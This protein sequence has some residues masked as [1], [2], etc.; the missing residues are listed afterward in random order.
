MDGTLASAGGTSQLSLH[1]T[2]VCNSKCGFCVVG[3]PLVRKDSVRH[4]DL[5]RF[6]VE[7]ASE[8]FESVNLHGGEPT[9]YPNL[10][11]LLEL[12]RALGYPRV[13]IQTN[14][15][16]LK[17]IAF[18][19]A[20]AHR[21]VELLVVSLHGAKATT[22]DRL[23]QA[24]GGFVETI[25]GLR[26][27]QTCDVDV[28]T[29]TV[30]TRQNLDELEDVGRLAVDLGV[31]HVN[32]S[33]LHPVGSGFF[34]LEAM[35]P[36]VVDLRDRLVAAVEA[37]RDRV[38]VT[39]EGFPFCVVRPF[40]HLAIER[41]KRSIKMLYRGS[42][43]DSYDVY[44]DTECRSFGPPCVDCKYR[45]VCGGVYKEYTERRGW[46]EFVPVV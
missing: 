18:V 15:R 41:Q 38:E 9:I 3:S 12:I 17:D 28:R 13:E 26:H 22:Q 23:T 14:G 19:E 34:A 33:N 21:G 6:L 2:D 5:V 4:E 46:T 40:E 20:L 45:G 10:M 1:I 35:I 27:A 37:I 25:E 11:E 39:L 31:K 32:F 44:M 16:R 43:F 24:P 7:N 8:G 42:V 29:N 36:S 30:V